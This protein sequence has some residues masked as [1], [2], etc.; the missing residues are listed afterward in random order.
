MLLMGMVAFILACSS[1]ATLLITHR[2][3]TARLVQFASASAPASVPTLTPTHGDQAMV[4]P[5]GADFRAYYAKMATTLGPAI[6]PELADGSSVR[7]I[8]ANGMVERKGDLFTLVPL[9]TLLIANR[10]GVALGPA[11]SPLTYAALTADVGTSS[12]TTA[13]WWWDGGKQPTVAGDFITQARTAGTAYG[14]YVPA[15]FVAYLTGLGD[16]QALIGQP[17]TQ[18]Q[19]VT[20]PAAGGA[21]HIALQAFADA[22]LWYDRDA[23]GTPVIHM[24]PVGQDYLAVFG[25]P[26]VITNTGQTVWTIGTPQTVRGAPQ[27]GTTATFLTPFAVTLAGDDQWVGHDLWYHIQWRNLNETRDGWVNASHLAFHAPGHLSMQIAGLDALAPRLLADAQAYGAN[28]GMAIYDPANGH[29]YAYNGAEELE[30]ASMIKVPI[31]LTLLHEAEAQGRGLTATEQAEATAMIEESDNDAE[32]A[33]YA[34]V[35][36]YD[37]VMGY[38][39]SIGITDLDFDDGSPGFS[40]FTALSSVRLMEDLR[41]ARILTPA[42][43]QYALSLMAN[44]IA[45]Q[46]VGIGDTAPA[47]ASWAMKIGY[48]IG[49]NNLWLMNAMGTV[50]YHGHA[51]DIAIYTQ[52]DGD[53][54]TSTALVDNLCRQA[55]RVLVGT[56]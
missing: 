15:P 35:G 17:V 51:Y 40:T 1:T 23:P 44:V 34:E 56:P 53:F 14:Y 31:L 43:C 29:Y 36:G 25:M 33:L 11:G 49:A 6:T 13:P 20:A 12:L 45:G 30:T 5:V 26:G 2:T 37:A 52:S 27:A 28:I 16:W 38:M 47:G 48:G 4:Q 3:A 46:Q 18:V 10:A 54:A 55:V 21:H 42:D 7:Q 50:T 24:Q 32:I 22:I 41:A 9:V 8:F 19:A 39:R